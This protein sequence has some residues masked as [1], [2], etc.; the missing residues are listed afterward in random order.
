MSPSASASP[1]FECVLNSG[2]VSGLRV[3]PSDR[4]GYV[5]IAILT[6]T[7]LLEEAHLHSADA[8]RL[9]LALLNAAATVR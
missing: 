3:A 4:G 1:T 8:H 5:V 6:S 2:T 7:G 9:A